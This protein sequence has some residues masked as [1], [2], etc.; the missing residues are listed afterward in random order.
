[1]LQDIARLMKEA[2]HHE[3][4]YHGQRPGRFNS[5]L[6]TEEDVENALRRFKLIDYKKEF[7]IGSIPV[8]F[9]NAGHILGSAMI[10]L[11]LGDRTLV[12]SGDLGRPGAPL[13]SDSE[14]NSRG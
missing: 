11:S 7:E 12:F 13:L 6:N 10:E 4:G 9:L 8:T 5:T 2:S 14:K 3:V 1:M